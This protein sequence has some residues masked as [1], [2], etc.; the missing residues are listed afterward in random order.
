VCEGWIKAV[1][2]VDKWKAREMA[3][4]RRIQLANAETVQLAREANANVLLAD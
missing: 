2:V 4:T 3:A 1:D